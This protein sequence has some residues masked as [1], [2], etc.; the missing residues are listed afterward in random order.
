MAFRGRERE[1]VCRSVVD[2]VKILIGVG[3]NLIDLL[4]CTGGISI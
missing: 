2:D 1:R 4:K 3:H